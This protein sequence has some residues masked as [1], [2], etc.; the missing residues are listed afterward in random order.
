M[1]HWTAAKGF[2][3]YK[4]GTLQHGIV[5]GYSSSTMEGY[6]NS[7]LCQQHRDQTVNQLGVHT[8]RWSS[9]LKQ[10]ATANSDCVNLRS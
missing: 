5:F 2:L 6:C 10:Q 4:A 1:K 9:Q 3:R 8:Q 7:R